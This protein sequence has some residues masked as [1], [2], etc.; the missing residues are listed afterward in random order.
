MKQEAQS[1]GA[2]C[3]ISSGQELNLKLCKQLL[4]GKS[5]LLS[6]SSNSS[7][8]KG[9][10]TWIFAPC[11][12]DKKFMPSPITIDRQGNLIGHAGNEQ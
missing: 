10:C 7:F 12:W 6:K 9:P 5:T 3:Y 8:F 2:W 4:T 11:T 1:S